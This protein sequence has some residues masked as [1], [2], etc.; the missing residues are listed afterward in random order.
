MT[1]TRLASAGRR[2]TWLR[3]AP[4]CHLGTCAVPQAGPMARRRDGSPHPGGSPRP[5]G[6]RVVRATVVVAVVALTVAGV[7][8]RAAVTASFAG[9]G[10][11]HWLWIP[12][13]IAF[14]SASMAAFAIMLRR[15]LAAGGTRIGVR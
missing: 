10:H 15:L 1:V 8:G 9:L 4:A 6:K 3:P 14:E 11:L 5:D 12:A 2:L 13:A 7:T